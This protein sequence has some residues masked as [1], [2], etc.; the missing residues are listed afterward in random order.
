MIVP[1]GNFA[2]IF[3]ITTGF[4][5][6]SFCSQRRISYFYRISQSTYDIVIFS[7]FI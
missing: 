5:P 1:A 7:L 6:M 2:I 3:R 4:S